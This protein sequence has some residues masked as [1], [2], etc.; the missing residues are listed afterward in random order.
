MSVADWVEI[1]GMERKMALE[2]VPRRGVL[3]A[4]IAGLGGS[5]LGLRRHRTD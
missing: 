5:C 2:L 4:G 3:Q 1:R